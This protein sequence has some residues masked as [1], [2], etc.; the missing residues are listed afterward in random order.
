MTQTITNNVN[1]NQT[2]RLSVQISLNGL[3]FLTHTVDNEVIDFHYH[4]FSYQAN[5]EELLIQI[6]TFIEKG[7]SEYSDVALIYTTQYV[8]IVPLALFNSDKP[9]EYLK[10]NTKIL[11]HDYVSYDTN[12]ALEMA[13]VYIPYMNINNYLYEHFGS[14]TYY[15]SHSVLIKHISS[16]EKFSDKNNVYIHVQ[17]DTFDCFIFKKGKLQL[18]NCYRYKTPEDFI[19]FILFNFEQCKLNPEVDTVLLLGNIEETSPL[20]EI[21]Y[22]YVRNIQFFENDLPQIESVHEHGQIPLKT[23]LT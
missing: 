8:T 13:T 4:E 11:A 16:K 12:E 21:V 14:F 10:F 5:P 3:S 18:A 20:F 2:Y 23:L 9:S 6:K 22:T 7:S 15:H 19:Y 17:K 1:T